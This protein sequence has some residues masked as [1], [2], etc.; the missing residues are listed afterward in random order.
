MLVSTFVMADCLSRLVGQVKKADEKYFSDR[1]FFT[2]MSRTMG[3]LKGLMCSIE[4]E[5]EWDHSI[6]TIVDEYNQC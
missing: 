2:N 6:N 5:I 3:H 4:A 1:R